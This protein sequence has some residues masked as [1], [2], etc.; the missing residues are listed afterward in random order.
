MV[1]VVVVVVMC[2]QIM[3]GE[4]EGITGIKG[5]IIEI[6]RSLIHNACMITLL[7][8]RGGENGFGV[9]MELY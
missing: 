1:S 8:V 2:C 3:R 9:D 6:M 7:L 4:G 5:A